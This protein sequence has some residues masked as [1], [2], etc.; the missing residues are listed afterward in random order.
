MSWRGRDAARAAFCAVALTVAL[1]AAAQ[2]AGAG[3]GGPDGVP[4]L[5]AVEA[6]VVAS[7]QVSV[8]GSTGDA[9][10]DAAILAEAR[11][12]LG[13][14]PGDRL[15]RSAL[16]IA[17][18]RL[19]EIAGVASVDTRLSSDAE[20]ARAQ[21]EVTLALVPVDV[22]E[23]PTG[24]LAGG[25]RAA[26]PILWQDQN[27]L[28][29]FHLNG[30]AGIYSDG[31]AWFGHPEVFTLGNPLVEDPAT[32]AQT[33]S[34]ATWAEA[35]VEFGLSGATRLGDSNVALYG[36]ATAIA[37]LAVGQDIFRG[38]TRSSLDLEKAY[39]GLL[40]GSDDRRRSV[41][42][43][44]GRQNFTLNDGFLISQF[45]S[46]WNAGPRPAVYLAPRT[47]HDFAAIGTIKYDDWTATAFYLDPNEYEPLESD[48][49]LAGAN[50]RYAFTNRFWVDASIIRALESKTRYA[51]PNGIVGTRDGLTTLAAH[52][53][54]ADPQVAPGVW[55]EGEIAHQ[56]HDDFD[57]DA[58]GGYTHVGY[59]A[60]DLPWTPSISYRYSA[61]SGDDPD[62]ATYERFD[63]LY[64][65]GLSEW[66]EGVSIS[67]ALNPANRSTH[68]VRLN[69]APDPRLN[70]TFDWH[71]HRALE[72]NNLGANPALATLSSRDLGQ[73]FSV[74]ARYALSRD[75]FLLG[76]ASVGLPGEAIRDATPGTD[77]PWTTLQAHLFWTF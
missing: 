12:R 3:L 43:S 56:R 6:R 20:P 60:R 4:L 11:R 68:R 51:T 73:E 22:P 61:R 17:Q 74:T 30:G 36:A 59:I 15:T 52:L 16:D 47:T 28:L 50:L 19:G 72:R 23:G 29:R 71:L 35:F 9:G 26:F 65:G 37:P 8:T 1:P 42:L 69:L 27:S 7:V 76:I 5:S 46:Q 31:N 14:R 49:V 13:L 38:D 32:G 67:K 18:L 70:L 40:W 21:V 58:C 39:V 77:E 62:T 53:R 44:F 64:A 55:V 75:I 34:R 41:N 57:M 10:R 2:E 25:G 45:G 63:P 48:T 66:L 33:R 24:M 54:W